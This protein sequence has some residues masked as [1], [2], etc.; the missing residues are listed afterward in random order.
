MFYKQN[1]AVGATGQSFYMLHGGTSWGWSAIPQN[2]TSYDYGAAITEGRQFDPKYDED[3]LIG[4]LH[5]VRGAAD[6]D[7]R[8]RRARR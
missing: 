5:P 8:P 1:I 6:Q 2:Y 3:K 7:R 4:V